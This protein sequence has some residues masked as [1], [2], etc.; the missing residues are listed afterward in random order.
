[1]SHAASTPRWYTP[2]RAAAS[3]D[4]APDAADLGTA[5]VL[6]MSMDTFLPD[7]PVCRAKPMPVARAGWV[8]RLSLRGKTAG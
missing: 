7:E 8:A 1:M 5:F 3:A 2:W 6:D 4:T